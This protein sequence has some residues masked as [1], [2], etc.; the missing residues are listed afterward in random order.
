MILSL[1]WLALAGPDGDLRRPLTHDAVMNWSR[2]QVEVTAGAEDVNLAKDN[3]PLE[4]HAIVSVDGRVGAACSAVPLRSSVLLQDVVQ[5]IED[6]S[7]AT[8]IIREG[9]YYRDGR[10]EV[11]GV[12]DVLPLVAGW[13]RSRAASPPTAGSDAPTGVVIDARGLDVDPVFAPRF[14][15]PSG[16]VLYD[17]ILWSDVAF[18]RAPVVWVSDPAHEA[19]ARAGR[20]PIFFVAEGVLGG[21]LV[22]G[23]EDTAAFAARV[24]GA[25][26]LGD[27]TVVV[28]IDP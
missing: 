7:R 25:R 19:A 17:S 21:D 27:G 11:V 16:E 23:A 4:Q 3:R 1:M 2:M 6:T 13:S 26:T 24:E 9:R 20:S 12:V 22:L 15:G 8:W 10:V 5:G 18:S 14:R 28:V